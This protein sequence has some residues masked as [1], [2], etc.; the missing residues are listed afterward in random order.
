M[1]QEQYAPIE[2]RY[3][4]EKLTIISKIKLTKDGSVLLK[5]M[6]CHYEWLDRI[7]N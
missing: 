5:E 3:L 4:Y 2:N 6:V 1:E 7:Q